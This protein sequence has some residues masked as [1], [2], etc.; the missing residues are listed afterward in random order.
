MRCSLSGFQY[1]EAKMDSFESVVATI[2]ERDGYWVKSTFKVELTKEE[3][4]EIG[5]PSSPRWELDL[6]AYKGSTNELLV[7][8]CKSY[9]DSPGVRCRAVDG[10]NHSEAKRYKLFNDDTLRRVVFSRLSKQLENSGACAQSPILMLALAAGKIATEDDRI[11]LQQYF[12]TKGWILFDSIWLK[13]RLKKI[14]KDSYENAVASVVAK[15]LL[16]P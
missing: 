12:D 5:R 8:E 2:L 9:L 13:D 10:S 3:K 14:S 11:K 6:V 7:V 16:R 15:L 1:K 4:R